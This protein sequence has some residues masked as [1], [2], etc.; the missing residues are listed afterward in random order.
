MLS[1]RTFLKG[2]GFSA[3]AATATGFYTWQLEPHWTEYVY[4][5]LPLKNL[6]PH[7]QGKRLIQISDIHIGDRVDNAYLSK[8]F[9]KIKSLNADII[10]Y[11]GDFMSFDRVHELDRLDE[12]MRDA[13]L[14]RAHTLGIFGNHD[15]GKGWSD[16]SIAD[17]LHSRLTSHGITVLRNQTADLNGLE[18]IG[19]EE[20]WSPNFIPDQIRPLLETAGSN[21]AAIALCHNPDGCDLDIWGNFQGWI[22]SGHTHGGQIKPPFLPPPPSSP[23]PTYFTQPANTP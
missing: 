16:A 8:Q 10:V 19:I 18:I 21:T 4:R 9:D 7:W 12:V 2:I 1:R 14:G 6:P 5:N 15:Y 11:T 17:Q 3:L 22:L 23:S 20:L 13:P